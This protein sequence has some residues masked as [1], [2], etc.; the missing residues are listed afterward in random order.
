MP[1]PALSEC[2]RF[3]DWSWYQNKGPAG[4]YRP[5]DVARFCAEHPEFDGAVLRFVWPN[6]AVDKHYAHYYDGWMAENK[7]VMGYG[8]PNPTKSAVSVVQD[9][10]RALGERIPKVIWGDW[11][12]ASTFEG[13]T[14]GQ[15]T[16]HM[17]ALYDAKKTYLQDVVHGEYSRAGWLDQRIEALAEI[18]AYLWWLAHWI[19]PPPDFKDQAEQINELDVLLPIDNNFTPYRGKVILIPV[20]KVKGWQGSSR[21]KIVPRG[22]SDMG[23]MLRS[24]VDPIYNGGTPPPP[25]PEKA[26]VEVKATVTQGNAEIVYG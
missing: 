14:K 26:I 8:W 25:A 18:R 4:L 23:Y 1:W 15:L 11:E 13:K 9:W 17:R 7:I 2:Y 21:G 12:E 20:E 22:T 16:S 5:F 10:K 6:G 3:V 19:Y 24:F